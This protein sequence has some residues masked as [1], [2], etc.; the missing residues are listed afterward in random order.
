MKTRI[1]VASVLM[2]A[3]PAFADNLTGNPGFEMPGL[4]AADSNQWTANSGGPAGTLSQRDSSNPRSGNW[5]HNIVAVGSDA[6]G[7][8]AGITQNSIADAGLL[9][10]APGSSVSLSFYGNYNFGPGGV[11]FYALRILNGAGAIV[12]D[13]GLQTIANSTNGYQLFTSPSLTVP[14]F[15]AAPDDT[16]AAFVEISVAAGAFSGST[17]SAFIDDVDVQGTVI[18]APA[19]LALMGGGLALVGRRRR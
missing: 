10:L 7:A 15:G 14:A 2:A 5:A 13:T 8:G 3:A 11:G 16:Y 9:S 4:T 6:A 18:P 12:A 17:A 1:I 19:S